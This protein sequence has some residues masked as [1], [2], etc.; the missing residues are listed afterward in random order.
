MGMRLTHNLKNAH[1]EMTYLEVSPV[2]IEKLT[3]KGISVSLP[4]DAI[5]FADVVILAVPDVALGKVSATFI[6]MMKSGALVVTLDP[7]AALAG[8]LFDRKDVAYFCLLYT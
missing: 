1:Y 7:A 3:E 4:N 5:P 2:G 8:K 6:P